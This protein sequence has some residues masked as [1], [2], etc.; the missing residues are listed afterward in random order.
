V[1]FNELEQ[2]ERQ[3]LKGATHASSREETSTTQAGKQRPF[4]PKLISDG[5]YVSR[6]PIPDFSQ[7]IRA[8]RDIHYSRRLW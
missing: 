2:Q 6:T 4:K 1:P 8:Q 3:P 5:Y 7:A